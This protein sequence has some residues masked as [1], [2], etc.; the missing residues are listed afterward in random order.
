MCR[1]IYEEKRLCIYMRW[2]AKLSNGVLI[3]IVVLFPMWVQIRG[4]LA[5][6]LDCIY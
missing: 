6:S 3:A 4:V 5:I 1:L 2:V